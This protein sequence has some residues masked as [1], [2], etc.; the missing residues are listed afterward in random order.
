MFRVGLP[1]IIYQ[2][3]EI[4]NPQLQL[5]NAGENYILTLHDVQQKM[6]VKAILSPENINQ[7]KQQ[8]S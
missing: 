2:S 8:L 3:L 1:E 7:I 4:K 5:I 6:E